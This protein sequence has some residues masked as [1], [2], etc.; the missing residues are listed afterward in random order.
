M[1]YAVTGISKGASTLS[2]GRK[3]V[4]ALGLYARTIVK[5]P[6]F[7]SR[8]LTQ[9]KINITL[10]SLE[11]KFGVNSYGC[12]KLLRVW[13]QASFLRVPKYNV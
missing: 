12:G 7:K 6:Y 10:Y 13:D 4:N 9:S 2:V 11:M 3:T 5:R 1:S 8:K